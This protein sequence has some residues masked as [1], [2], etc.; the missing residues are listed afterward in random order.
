MVSPIAGLMRNIHI[1]TTFRQPM[2]NKHF[3]FQKYARYRYYYW[4]FAC[5]K[6]HLPPTTNLYCLADLSPAWSRFTVIK[7]VIDVCP[8]D[9]YTTSCDQD[10]PSCT[11]KSLPSCICGCKVHVLITHVRHV[12]VALQLL[13]VQWYELIV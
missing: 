10:V 8:L 7:E 3:K 13:A 6:I 9:E 1:S 5:K 12:V 2:N 11:W 4:L